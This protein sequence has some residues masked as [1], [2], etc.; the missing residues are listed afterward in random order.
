VERSPGAYPGCIVRSERWQQIEK[1]VGH[2]E[3]EEAYAEAEQ[4]GFEWAMG[5]MRSFL[6]G[7][8]AAY[9]A[10]EIDCCEYFGR[11]VESATYPPYPHA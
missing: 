1:A 8:R 7:L 5:L 10:G 11:A 4:A 3:T 2:A 6:E 9:E